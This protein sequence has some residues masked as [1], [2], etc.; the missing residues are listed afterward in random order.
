MKTKI[1]FIIIFPLAFCACGQVEPPVQ[2]PFVRLKPLSGVPV[3]AKM[4][5]EG[6]PFH[7]RGDRFRDPFTPITSDL[8]YR[9]SSIVVPNINDLILHGIV[10]DG[11]QS[12]AILK[13]GN[14]S[15]T[16]LN[17]RVYDSMQRLIKGMSGV[18]KTESVVVYGR[19]GA[20][21]EIKLREKSLNE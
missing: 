4:I 11:N 15:Y 12:I 2:T 20:S 10:R 21:R 17:G 9:S 6:K 8:S 19:D 7:Y 18:I 13:S 16:L 3:T 1:F 5:P 14:C